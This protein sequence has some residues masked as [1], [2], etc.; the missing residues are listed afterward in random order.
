MNKRQH[1][2]DTLQSLIDN[3][4][5]DLYNSKKRFIENHETRSGDNYHLIKGQYEVMGDIITLMENTII[6][7]NSVIEKEK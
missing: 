6:G 1:T 2:I 7:L 5:I 3:N 4:L